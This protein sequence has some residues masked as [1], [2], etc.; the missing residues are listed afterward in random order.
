MYQVLSQSNIGAKL[1]KRG[2][3]RDVYEAD[4]YLLIVATDRISAFDVVLPNPIPYK[5]Y[6]LN[7]ISV[8]W[9]KFLSGVVKT[10]FITDDVNLFPEIFKKSY[11][12]VVYRSM[13]VKK[14]KPLPVECIVRGYISG[15]AWKEYKKYGSVCGIKLPEGLRESDKLSEPIF[16]PSTKAET[17]HDENITFEKVVDLIGRELAEKVRDLSLRI[18]IEAEE[19]ARKKGII[20]ADTKFE[21]GLDEN[22]EL[23]LIDEVLTPDSSRFWPLSEY[24][25]GKPQPSFDKQYVRDYLESINWDKKPPAPE[26][27]EEV[28]KKTRDKY[29]EA[30]RL[31]TGEDLLKKLK[32]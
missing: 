29:L 13:L 28:I 27:P 7:Q 26:L 16:T 23:I 11:E 21:F 10:H 24:E 14:A 3:V 9:F 32:I 4:G 6:V 8:F 15:S 31:L 5:G 25:P 30:Y 20:I 22:G 18:Y 2:K 1:I 17:G 12:Q 19:Y